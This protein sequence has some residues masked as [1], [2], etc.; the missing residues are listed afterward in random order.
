MS[1]IL[2]YF[3]KIIGKEMSKPNRN[4]TESVLEDILDAGFIFCRREFESTNEIY[5]RGDLRLIYDP[6]CD[7][8]LNCY[9]LGKG[10]KM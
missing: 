8:I 1:E 10:R 9:V 3:A 5:K 2:K 6:E 4:K 7:R